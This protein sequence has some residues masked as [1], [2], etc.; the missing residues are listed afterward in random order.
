MQ[1]I[2]T[3]HE[4][5]HLFDLTHADGGV[6]SIG[7]GESKLPDGSNEPHNCLTSNTRSNY[8]LPGHIKKIQAKDYPR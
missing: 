3:V 6:M 8:L 5:L 1:K 7:N 2:N 4:V